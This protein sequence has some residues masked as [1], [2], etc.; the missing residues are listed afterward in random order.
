MSDCQAVGPS[1]CMYWK[2]CRVVCVLL[3]IMG[4]VGGRRGEGQGGAA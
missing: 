2:V 4:Q 1:L 3:G